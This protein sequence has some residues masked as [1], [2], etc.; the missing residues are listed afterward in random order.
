MRPPLSYEND[1]F[2]LTQLKMRA[3]GM[4]PTHGKY[5]KR[6]PKPK[7]KKFHQ[8]AGASGVAAGQDTSHPASRSDSP[9]QC[10]TPPPGEHGKSEASGAVSRVAVSD[11]DTPLA[12]AM[13]DVEATL[14]RSEVIATTPVA[15]TKTVVDIQTSFQVSCCSHN[16]NTGL[17]LLRDSNSPVVGGRSPVLKPFSQN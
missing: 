10:A 7:Q 15:G 8:T 1:A 13:S 9:S 2:L 3:S 16:F 12:G 14:D 4:D 17:H 6:S 11:A 5:K